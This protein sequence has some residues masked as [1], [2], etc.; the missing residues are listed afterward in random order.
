[1]ESRERSHGG[2]KWSRGVSKNQWSADSHHFN[3]EQDPDPHESEKLD[4]DPHKKLISDPQ[5]AK[6]QA[7]LVLPLSDL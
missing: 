7:L 2:T 6:Q 1:M 4:P 3:D 5:H